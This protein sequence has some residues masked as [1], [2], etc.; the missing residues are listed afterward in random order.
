MDT[1]LPETTAQSFRIIDTAEFLKKARISKSTLCRLE[2]SDPTFP[3]P[4]QLAARGCR[5]WLESAVDAYLIAKLSTPAKPN[6]ARVAKAVS[7]AAHE[8]AKEK[9]RATRL[10]KRGPSS[11]PENPELRALAVAKAAAAKRSRKTSVSTA[12]P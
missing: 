11:S 7:A 9:R 12:T 8:C 1:S 3:K 2:K 6:T 5:L 10:K 4:G